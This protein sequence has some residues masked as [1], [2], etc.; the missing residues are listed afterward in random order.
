MQIRSYSSLMVQGTPSSSKRLGNGH[1]QRALLLSGA[2]SPPNSG[3][4]EYFRFVTLTSGKTSKWTPKLLFSLDKDTNETGLGKA[5]DGRRKP[6]PPTSRPR[7]P[8][9]GCT[10]RLQN[11]LHGYKAAAVARLDAN[12]QIATPK[13]PA[14]MLV[15]SPCMIYVTYE[16]WYL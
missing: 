14:A 10:S 9:V 4:M 7:H 8:R 13:L 2:R 15:A 3:W 1:Q 12:A 6:T 16:G 11:L 5:Q